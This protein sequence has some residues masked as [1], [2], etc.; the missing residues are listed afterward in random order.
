MNFGN[1]LVAVNGVL[2]VGFGLGFIVAPGFFTGLFTGGV[3]STPSAAIDMR[4]T[5]GGLGLGI[6]I[7]LLLCAKE[8][9]R[10][11]LLGSL[12]VLASIILGRIVGLVVDGSPTGYMYIFLGAEVLFLLLVIYALRSP[13]TRMTYNE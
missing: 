5:Y 7:W 11:G 4:A 8:N 3:L 12:F 1:L 9:V 10:V 6:G 13:A 2:F